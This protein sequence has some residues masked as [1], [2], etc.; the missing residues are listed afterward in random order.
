M[1]D[2]QKVRVSLVD[3]DGVTHEVVGW[4]RP[5]QGGA[6]FMAEDEPHG[7]NISPAL[8]W[9]KAG[10]TVTPIVE[11]PTGLG[12]VVEYREEGAEPQRFVY[13]GDDWWLGPGSGVRS[14]WVAARPFTVL[15]EG[16]K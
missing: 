2:M 14:D 6:V 12:A 9:M 8:S 15:S 13:V 7:G 16:V 3:A 4:R 10:V 1:T 5:G 11:L